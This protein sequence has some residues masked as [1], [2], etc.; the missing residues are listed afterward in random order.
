M[1]HVSDSSDGSNSQEQEQERPVLD[2]S[3]SAAAQQS[4]NDKE[5]QS[6]D[7]LN[8]KA[9]AELEVKKK[10][11]LEELESALVPKDGAEVQQ[12]L[13]PLNPVRPLGIEVIDETALLDTIPYGTQ[14]KPNSVAVK[15]GK[16]S[17]KRA[18]KGNGAKNKNKEEPQPQ[19][20]P[21]IANS[22]NNAKY[23]RKEMEALRFVNVAQQRKF[24]KA[25]YAALETA[26]ANEYDTLALATAQLQCLPKKKQAPPILTGAKH[27][28]NM[29]SESQLK[30]SSENVIPVDPSCSHSLMGVDGCSISEECSEDDD[31][32]DD[33]ASIQ[34]PA[35]LV[36][37]EPNF[38][39]GPPEDGWEYLR[40]VRWEAD[41]IPKVKVA[42]LD[43]SKHEK[44]QSAYM[45]KIPDIAKCPEHL[46]PMKQWEDVFLAEFSAL[47]RNLSC[48]E[49]SSA[50]HSSNL[51]SVHSS[52]LLGNNCGES[53]SAMNRDVLLNNH[54]NIGKAIDQPINM[55]AE[56]RDRALHLKN[57]G[58]K[59]SIDQASSSSLSPPLLSAILGM[60][61]VARVSMLQKR[62]SLLEP[63]NTITRNDCM[64]LFAL[65]ATVD[66]PLDADTSAALRSLLRK[67]ASIRAGKA[68][69]DDEVVMLNI[70]ATISGRYFGQSEN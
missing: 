57:P 46:L 16:H 14:K 29:D 3:D 64:C 53:A 51:Q 13:P 23:S 10:R 31:S 61:S 48:L 68:E 49:G 47:R 6:L 27:C 8:D 22:K 15:N 42:K 2:V 44:E 62:I 21:P 4:G 55:I 12:D 37:G 66:D 28:E 17:R 40:R 38:D 7:S 19:P 34:R 43:R 60:D 20:Q 54:L 69:L 45:P 24:W 25:I 36:E 39:S 1:A 65:C 67:C 50:M 41:Q 5:E 35:F 59:T 56:D 30:E 52:Q 33:N 18:G 26:V 70:L 58:S 11:L 63:A 9:S 32:E